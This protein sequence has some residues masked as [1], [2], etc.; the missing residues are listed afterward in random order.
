MA[1]AGR[2]THIFIIPWK[3]TPDMRAL[4]SLVLFLPLQAQTINPQK[5]IDLT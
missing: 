4:L 5:L 3:Y 1:L 2:A